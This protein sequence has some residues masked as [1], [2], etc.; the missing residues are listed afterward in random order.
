VSGIDSLGNNLSWNVQVL[1]VIHHLVFIGHVFV[2]CTLNDIRDE[3]TV[4][5]VAHTFNPSIQEAK[6]DRFP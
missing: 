6:T 1:E 3:I 5:V 4:G 2:E